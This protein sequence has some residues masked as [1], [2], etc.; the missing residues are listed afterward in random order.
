MFFE[1]S[2]TDGENVIKAEQTKRR[3]VLIMF[4]PAGNGGIQGIVMDSF[5]MNRDG[6][7]ANEFYI[8]CDTEEGEI[9]RIEDHGIKKLEDA[10]QI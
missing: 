5:Y 9:K 4:R 7:I 3:L 6:K 1:N 2:L 10:F 8:V